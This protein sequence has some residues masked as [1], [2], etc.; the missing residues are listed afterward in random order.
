MRIVVTPTSY[1]PVCYI[2]KSLGRKRLGSR[3]V[4]ANFRTLPLHP[5]T[6]NAQVPLGPISGGWVMSSPSEV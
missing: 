4:S 3:N 2:N 1:V 5:P 6:L